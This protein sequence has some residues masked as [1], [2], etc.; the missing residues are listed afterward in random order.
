MT[1]YSQE[2][3][4]SLIAYY[5]SRVLALEIQID[6]YKYKT[7]LI[8]ANLEIAQNQLKWTEKN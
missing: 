5:H 1:S 3:A 6:E 8:E 4:K 7:Q 2:T